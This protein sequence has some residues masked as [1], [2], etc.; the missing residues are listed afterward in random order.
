MNYSLDELTTPLTKAE[1]QQAIYDAISAHGTNT[2]VWK[3][4]AV[5]RAMIGGVAIVLA[6]LSS[7]V[8]VIAGGGF[9]ALATGAWLTLVARYVFGVER[10]AA[11]FAAGELTLV[12]GG[13][14]IF[15]FAAGEVTFEHSTSGAQYRN[16]SAFTLGIGETKD[17]AI[18]AVEAGTGGT[19][20]V[21]TITTIVTA[22]TDVTASNAATLT[23]L[24]EQS[25]LE[26]RSSCVAYRDSKSPNGPKGSYDYFAKAAVRSD[27]TSIGVTR[28]RSVADGDGG[29]TLYA[30]TASGAISGD[31]D[32]PLTDLGAIAKNCR[33]NAEPLT[34]TLTT[35]SAT[36]ATVDVTYELWAWND[37]DLTAAPTGASPEARVASQILLDLTAHFAAIPIGGV[38]A[39][40]DDT[41]FADAIQTVIGS[42]FAAVYRVN[43]SLPAGD[44]VLTEGQ[45]PVVGT[46]TGVINLVPRPL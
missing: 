4:T 3:P 28:T 21:G 9:L 33:E 32:N 29:V 12:N 35:E 2:T 36:N 19:A 46:V 44:T 38:D 10:R 43:M 25:D 39:D 13:G 17:I 11:T 27:G 14:G 18:A 22:M 16:T 1:I 45:A 23:G 6:A 20:G 42:S 34:V 40:T 30:A 7:L 41:V 24:A 15:S 37:V 31:E 8:A 26:L 5:T